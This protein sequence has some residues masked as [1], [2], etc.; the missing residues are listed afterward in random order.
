MHQLLKRL[1]QFWTEQGHPRLMSFV[2]TAGFAWLGV[3]LLRKKQYETGKCCKQTVHGRWHNN[4][5]DGSPLYP[6]Q[7]G[8]DHSFDLIIL[9]LMLP[10]L[11]GVSLCP[12]LPHL[13]LSRNN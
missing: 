9:D 10:R 6:A 11:D 4:R 8:P 13:G 2:A 3:C 7:C 12:K 5:C 1:A